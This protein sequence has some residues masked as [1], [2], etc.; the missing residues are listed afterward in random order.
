MAETFDAALQQEHA[1]TTAAENAEREQLEKRIEAEFE[2]LTAF[3]S[4]LND[5]SSKPLGML[6]SR[7]NDGAFIAHGRLTYALDGDNLEVFPGH[8]EGE[9]IKLLWEMYMNS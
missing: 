8:L 7:D 2:R 6:P 4:W 1:E 5:Q 9:S 3:V